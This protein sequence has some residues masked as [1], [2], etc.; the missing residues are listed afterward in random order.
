MLR[1]LV[2]ILLGGLLL[3]SCSL[4][5]KKSGGQHR[6]RYEPY[7]EYTL[8][9]LSQ[10][11][12]G[13]V[14]MEKRDPRVGKLDKLF[15]KEMPDIKRIGIVVFETEIQGTRSGLSENDKIYPTEQGK[16]LITEKFLNIW[17][18]G[19][20]LMASGLDY[21]SVADVK[22]SKAITQYGLSVPDYIKTERTKIE[23]DDIQWL[24]PGKAT[25]LFTI[26]N[27]REMRDLSFMLVPA[28]E[29]MS[30]PKWSEH[31]KIFLNDICKELNLDAV[32][33]L[34]SEVSWT[35][36]KKDKFT[37]VNVP[38]EMTIQIKGTTLIPAGK[39]HERLTA[40]K[41]REQQVINVAYRYHE[42][43][44]KLPLAISIPEEEKNFEQI[45]KR[46]LDPMFKAYRDLT[47]MMIDR[48]AGEIRKTH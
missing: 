20:P 31:N 18:E 13:V 15:A 41:E 21:V 16:Q 12:P 26:I 19:M 36:G 46:L 35:A 11:A 30:G 29:L 48:M 34:M 14:V 8:E 25:P 24:G 2:F 33:I 44:L 9:D 27:P 6:Y 17:E 42:G 5:S 47:L 22:K 40:L 23:Q 28:S 37:N 39:Y 3:T 4:G 7:F 43:A 1:F 45:E 10:L 38:E 32:L